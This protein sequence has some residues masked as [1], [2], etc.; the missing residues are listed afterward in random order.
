MNLS[1]LGTLVIVQVCPPVA[2][3]EKP[4]LSTEG[5]VIAHPSWGSVVFFG[6]EDC[7]VGAGA[8]AVEGAVDEAAE[9]LGFEGVDL[10]QLADAVESGDQLGSADR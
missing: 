9:V 7:F 8:P 5:L 6:F 2:G 4:T 1:V 3:A 10:H